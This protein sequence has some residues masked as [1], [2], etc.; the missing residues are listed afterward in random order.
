M[1]N[2]S[3]SVF[4][5]PYIFWGLQFPGQNVLQ[6][7]A[8]HVNINGSD[9][10]TLYF[11]QSMPVIKNLDQ[12]FLQN[13]LCIASALEVVLTI[14]KDLCACVCAQFCP[15]LC[16]CMDCSPPDS[17]CPWDF[18]GKNTGVGCFFLLQ[19]IFLTQRLNPCLLYLLHRQADSLSEEKSI[20][21]G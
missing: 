11:D 17:S 5:K 9:G 3:S 10:G 16:D 6:R 20:Q 2:T 21:L 7:P 13:Q 12:L 8:S 14:L 4:Q 15:T 19:V 1:T 18:P